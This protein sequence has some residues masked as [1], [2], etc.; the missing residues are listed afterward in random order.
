MTAP[1][2][3][4]MRHFGTE[5][6]YAQKLAGMPAFAGRMLMGYA[7]LKRNESNAQE[8]ADVHEQAREMN[9]ELAEVRSRLLG[10]SEEALHHTHAPMVLSSGHSPGMMSGEDV[11]VGF[12]EGMVR[13][14]HAIGRDLVYLD[15]DA[16]VKSAGIGTALG[17]AAKSIGKGLGAAGGS[18]VASGSRACVSGT[19]RSRSGPAPPRRSRKP[20][21]P[22]ATSR[23]GSSSRPA[24][25]SRTP[26]RTPPRPRPTP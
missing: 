23:S 21:R 19:P 13:L 10:P 6:V 12:D 16:M 1:N 24:R 11:P 4:L 8:T 22:R 3:A 25:R 15:L 14:A 9:Q 5:D 7:N 20:R 2:Q 18:D 26:P 17:G